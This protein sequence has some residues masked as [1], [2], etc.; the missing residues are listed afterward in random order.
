M[1]NEENNISPLA[2]G[3]IK[4]SKSLSSMVSRPKSSRTAPYLF[5]V[6]GRMILYLESPTHFSKFSTYTAKEKRRKERTMGIYR[7]ADMLHTIADTRVLMA[8]TSANNNSQNR[9]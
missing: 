6:F 9:G 8:N 5:I 7:M 3:R 2:I 4:P 1:F